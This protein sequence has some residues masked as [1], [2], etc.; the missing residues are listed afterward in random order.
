MIT[1]AAYYDNSADNPRNPNRP[2]Q[3]VR[4]GVE[5]KDEMCACHLE[6]LPDDAQRLRSVSAQVPVR[7]AD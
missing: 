1:L 3:R 7:P 5:T 6:F 2:P 4:Y